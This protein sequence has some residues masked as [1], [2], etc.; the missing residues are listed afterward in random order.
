MTSKTRCRL[1]NYV[2][3]IYRERRRLS[4]SLF[5]LSLGL[6][7]AP[8][9]L[10]DL[11]SWLPSE[12]LVFIGVV[13][14]MPLIATFLPRYR[15]LLEIFAV[16]DL[17]FSTLGWVYP[18]SVA[19]FATVENHVLQS[20][21]LYIV[22][23]MLVYYFFYGRWSD[24]LPSPRT[25]YGTAHLRS[26]LDLPALWFGL[27]PTPG[28]ADRV[29]EPDVVAIEYTDATHKSVRLITWTP[30]HQAGE[31]QVHFDDYETFS[32]VKMRLQIVHGR[33][34]P[35]LEGA[36]EFWMSDK[37]AYRRF[38]IR[39]ELNNMPLRRLLRAW[40]D[41]TLGRIMEAR[42]T[43]VEKRASKVKAQSSRPHAHPLLDLAD[44]VT[45]V[46]RNRSSKSGE[47]SGYRTAYGRK[48]S[49]AEKSALEGL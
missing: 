24:S 16:S 20:T 19:N 22:M 36:T 5:L 3:G 21:L 40:L 46:R 31:V 17:L 26:K 34:D 38:D 27:V 39:A 44:E 11:R 2:R 28:H 47:P 14:A 8:D 10:P 23:M 29:P 35:L 45:T 15:H 25:V 42:L 12:L 30:E 37:G 7:V 1:R 9:R 32:Y 18:Q 33:R 48:L 4:I 6:W 13:I 49:G 43:G 41:D